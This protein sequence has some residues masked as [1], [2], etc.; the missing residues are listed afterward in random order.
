MKTTQVLHVTP[1]ELTNMI[2]KEL[3][4]QVNHLQ[5]NPPPEVFVR[6]KAVAK[7]FSVTKSCVDGWARNG[8]IPVHKITGHNYFRMSEVIKYIL[9]NPK[10][11]VELD[12]ATIELAEKLFPN[13]QN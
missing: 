3:A 12:E 11:S 1:E 5:S 10:P 7:Q 6:S 9:E 13:Y 2:C 4:K 8:T